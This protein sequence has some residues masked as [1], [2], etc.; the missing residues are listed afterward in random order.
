MEK[1]FGAIASAPLSL[2]LPSHRILSFFSPTTHT[3]LAADVLFSFSLSCAIHWR[4]RLIWVSVSR[5]CELGCK[6]AAAAALLLSSIFLASARELDETPRAYRHTLYTRRNRR[7]AQKRKQRG[8]ARGTLR[9]GVKKKRVSIYI[10]TAAARGKWIVSCDY[11]RTTRCCVS[12][13]VSY[14]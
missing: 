4:S 5:T 13:N 6:T 11:E 9:N 7:G 12:Y 2:S 10:Y 8:R 14:I 1:S 3:L